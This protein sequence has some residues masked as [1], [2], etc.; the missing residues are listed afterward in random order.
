MNKEKIVFSQFKHEMSKPVIEV[1]A[2]AVV[3]RTGK[4]HLVE[5]ISA[6]GAELILEEKIEDFHFCPSHITSFEEIEMKKVGSYGLRVR[7]VTSQNSSKANINIKTLT[8]ED[9]H[10]S[11]QEVET[12]ISS[13][14][15]MWQILETIGFKVFFSITKERTTFS[16]D[17]FTI[18]IDDIDDFGLAVEAE[19]LISED[20]VAESKLRTKELLR[21]L[22]ITDE[23]F[24]AKSVPNILM[25]TKSVF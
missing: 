2:R 1:E 9:D 8:L 15:A 18:V 19:L 17:D 10:S 13:I 21:K 25:K 4:A 22:G 24:I 14:E 7:R 12:E 5:R 16:L 3:S 20:K 11:W 6:L 23:A